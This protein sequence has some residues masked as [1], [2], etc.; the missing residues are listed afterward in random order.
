MLKSFLFDKA[1]YLAADENGQ[2]V[3]LVVDYKNNTYKL[4]GEGSR[5]LRTELGVIAADLL[6]RKHKVNFAD[7]V[8]VY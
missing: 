7:H 5:E 4:V 1:K 8:R 6:K 3:L 2:E